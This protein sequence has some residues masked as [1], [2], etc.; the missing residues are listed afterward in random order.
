M[1]LT[2][3]L[4]QA[5]K[6]LKPGL[7]RVL[8]A[9]AAL[10]EHHT[11]EKPSIP[12]ESQT[13]SKKKQRQTKTTAKTDPATP[14]HEDMTDYDEDDDEAGEDS[15]LIIDQEED[16]NEQETEEPEDEEET[17]GSSLDTHPDV[18][19]PQTVPKAVGIGPMEQIMQLQ[20]VPPTYP[21]PH[22]P[23]AKARIAHQPQWIGPQM[24]ASQPTAEWWSI[25]KGKFMYNKRRQTTTKR[26]QVPP[27]KKAKKQQQ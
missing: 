11:G 4:Q 19:N 12:G 24:P 1:E 18:K 9:T 22:P 3:K 17:P 16:G 15:D 10:V 5:I 20:S 8:T 25:N 7:K 26:A 14:T 27:T 21:Y 23:P 6:G 13:K 2:F